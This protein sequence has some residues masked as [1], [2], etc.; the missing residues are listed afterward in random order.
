ML[1][2]ASGLGTLCSVLCPVCGRIPGTPHW[3]TDGGE[4]AQPQSW[5]PMWA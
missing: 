1:L 2:T 3:E 4:A 5:Y